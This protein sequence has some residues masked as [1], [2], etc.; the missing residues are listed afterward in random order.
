MPLSSLDFPSEAQV[1]FFICG[2]LPDVWEGM[3]GSYMGKNWSSSEYLIK[4][5]CSEDEKVVVYLMKLYEAILVEYR[6]EESSKK[7]KA[8]DR[9]SA[10]GGKNFTHN[11]KG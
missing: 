1:A 11:V 6:A 5:Y 9:K 3:S 10:S 2:L 4:L 7:Q 8:A